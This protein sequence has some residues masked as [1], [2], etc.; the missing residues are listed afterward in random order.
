MKIL[1]NHVGFEPQAPKLALLQASA[2]DRPQALILLDRESRPVQ[3]IA[4]QALGM[5]EGWPEWHYWQADFSAWTQPGQY[6]LW[7]QDSAPPVLSHEFT[8]A[9][10][11]LGAQMLSD[12]LNHFKSQRCT[13]LYDR[14]DRAA[15]EW[16]G[17]ARRDV[18]GGWFDA[19][20]D[21]SKYLSHL[22]YANFMNPQQTP[23]LA[24]ALMAGR[25]ALP[26]Q[27]RWFDERMV[28]EALHGAD[29]LLR[30]QHSSG[31]FYMTLF[32]GWSKA[33]EQRELCAFTTQRGVRSGAF[34]AGFRQGGGL[35]IAALA[36]AAELPR[37]GEF[38]RG[39]YLAAARRGF[40]H[41]QQHNTRYLDD[42]CENFIDDYCALLAACE[43]YS[44]SGEPVF[45]D[46]ADRRARR[47]LAQQDEAGRFWMDGQRR[48]SYFHA[49]EAGLPYLALLRFA[50]VLPA[51]PLAS[52][53]RQSVR[54]GLQAEMALTAAP[55][56]PFAYP[57][58]WVAVDG[59]AGAARFFMP[60]RNGSGYWWQGENA[61]LASLAAAAGGLAALEGPEGGELSAYAQGA[62]DW[63]LGR[64]PFDVCMLQGW[65]RNN[66]RYEPGYYNACGGVC[67][68]ITAAPGAD[69]GIAFLS[70]EQ[71]DISQ[72]WRWT[73][74]WLPHGAWLFL[75]LSLRRGTA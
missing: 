33:P 60:Q 66:P 35:A 24:W 46:A 2:A 25:A 14:A 34:Q 71:T 61:R 20:G 42:G 43:L 23:L 16:G 49:V 51:S 55:G 3:E 29:F 57:R 72:S 19:S 58:Q 63:I 53:A 10:D 38:S 62:L 64:N 56:N 30:M 52:A 39:D 18:S 12:L 6:R 26:A 17:G 44:A 7:L 36:R 11:C 75:A 68:G 32:D 5:A 31:F 74:Q 15:P 73:E 8:V 4:L 45:A 69:E 37:D 54:R 22:S 13:G 1:L 65:G 47:M 41:L 27:P 59:A 67:N 70:P 28:D 40:A 48:Q 9:S 21:C 50:A